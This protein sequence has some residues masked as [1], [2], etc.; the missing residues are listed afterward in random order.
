[1]AARRLKR[2]GKT[3]RIWKWQMETLGLEL[4]ATR[5][6]TATGAALDAAKETSQLAMMADS[7]KD[8]LEQAMRWM[9]DYG[10]LGEV[11]VTL[12][13]NTDF[14]VSMLTPQEIQAMLMAVNTGNMSRITFIEEMKRRGFVRDDLDTDE[15]I[16]RIEGEAPEGLT[17]GGE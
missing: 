17:D 4:L 12:T 5:T 1:M 15:E 6:Q 3:S 2:G 7:L 14:G 16:E 13:V 11:D 10:G 9:G 8:A